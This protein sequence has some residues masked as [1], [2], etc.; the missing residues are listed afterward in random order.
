M[1]N[2]N[3]ILITSIRSYLLRSSNF[4]LFVTPTFDTS[5]SRPYQNVLNVFHGASLDTQKRFDDFSNGS[6]ILTS[7]HITFD[8]HDAS[9]DFMPCC[10]SMWCQFIIIAN[11][12]FLLP[13]AQGGEI[14]GIFLLRFVVT[15]FKSIYF[16]F[17]RNCLCLFSSQNDLI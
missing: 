5:S 10:H 3:S 8:L 11:S 1:L 7:K 6:F 16:I 2:E 15:F 17:C 14:K 4:Y 13:E 9:E 12:L